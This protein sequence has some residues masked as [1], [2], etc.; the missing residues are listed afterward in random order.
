MCVHACVWTLICF[1]FPVVFTSPDPSMPQRGE[2]AIH[3]NLSGPCELLLPAAA[4]Q[5]ARSHLLLQCGAAKGRGDFNSFIWTYYRNPHC[6]S[7]MSTVLV[8]VFPA[9]SEN[10]MKYVSNNSEK[11]IWLKAQVWFSSNSLKRELIHL[12][13]KA[14]GKILITK[15]FCIWLWWCIVFAR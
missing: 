15:G 7:T 1:S 9:V 8:S 14:Y 3:L 4:Q 2:A 11:V 5:P 10:I 6:T 13:L 12:V